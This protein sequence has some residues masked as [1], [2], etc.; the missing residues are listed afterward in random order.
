[1][2][3][4]K[5]KISLEVFPQG[6][7]CPLRCFHCDLKKKPSFEV[8]AT[9]VEVKKTFSILEEA[10]FKSSN[11]FNISF[12]SSVNDIDQTT[13]FYHMKMRTVNSILLSVD[14]PMKTPYEETVR[15]IQDIFER[16]IGG[17]PKK[18]R[19]AFLFKRQIPD[20]AELSYVGMVYRSLEE[21]LRGTN[22]KQLVIQMSSNTVSERFF[23]NEIDEI[24]SHIYYFFEDTL[25]V[26]P[27]VEFESWYG[28]VTASRQETELETILTYRT[29]RRIKDVRDLYTDRLMAKAALAQHIE[30]NFF[31]FSIYTKGCSAESFNSHHK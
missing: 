5:D 28:M 26:E 3:K 12:S 7:I 6:E 29:L 16:H 23:D 9:D 10:L 14:Q 21:I 2:S 17:Y 20:S 15:N 18:I 13:D 25:E 31:S 11:P 27:V 24:L 19:I 8:S 4:Y 1:M 22:C 30:E